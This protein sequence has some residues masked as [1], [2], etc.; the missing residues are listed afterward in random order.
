MKK[1]TED[2]YLC[3]PFNNRSLLSVL[4]GYNEQFVIESQLL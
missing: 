4:F 3:T 1:K 2:V